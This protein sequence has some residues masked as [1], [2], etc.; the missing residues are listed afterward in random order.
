MCW[1]HSHYAKVD[2]SSNLEMKQMFHDIT[3]GI[4]K[5]PCRMRI[6]QYY[7]KNYYNSRIKNIF[8]T[9]WAAAQA[10][11]GSNKPSRINVLNSVT[12]RLWQNESTTFKT[13][14]ESKRNEDHAKELE[15]HQKLVKELQTTPNSAETYHKYVHY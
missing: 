10:N 1:C 14:L 8:E 13:W 7:L 9:E 3:D 6:T 15:E 11:G 2:V 4:P 12:N 5:A